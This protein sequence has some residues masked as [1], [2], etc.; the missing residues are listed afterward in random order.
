MIIKN[1]MSIINLIF[2]N[3]NIILKLLILIVLQ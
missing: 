3:V 1:L 2:C